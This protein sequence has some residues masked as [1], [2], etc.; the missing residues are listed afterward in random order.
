[1]K[2]IIVSMLMFAIVG[3]A[4]AQTPEEKAV[5]KAQ[6]AALKAAQKEAKAQVQQ[7]MKLRDAVMALYT[8]NQAEI[9]KGDK[10][11]KET[12]VKNE[13]QIKIQSL[14]AQEL[15]S[16]AFASGNIE[17][18]LM[19][20]AGK[21]YDDVCSQ[22]LNPELQL[23]AAHETFDTLTFSKAIDGVCDG[24]YAVL[25][26]GK[27]KDELQKPIILNSELKMPKLMTYYAYLCIFYT[28]TKNIDKAAEAMEKYAAFPTKYPKVANDPAITNP[29]YPVEQFAFN[30]YL[31]AY[32]MKKYDICEK[33]YE[34]AFAYDNPESHNFVVSSRPQIYLNQGD[35]ANWENSLKEMI[36]AEPNSNNAEVATQNL[37]VHYSRKGT[38]S[39]QK[40]ADEI[41]AI[42]PNN[43]IA[44]YGKGY[45][46]FASEKFE[47]A[48]GYY[49]KAMEADPDYYDAVYMAGM[50]Q[51]R[52]AVT[53]NFKYVDGKKYKSQAEVNAAEEKY[54]KKYFRQALPLFEKAREMQPDRSDDWASAL[55]TI[56]KNL[57]QKDKADELKQYLQ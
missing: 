42:D 36:K 4:S 31:T 43:K 28:E 10:A 55:S 20:D 35:T 44:N 7:G 11:N 9:A 1:M 5:A 25:E 47:D 51:Y 15:L 18:K 53:N 8:A 26:Y 24:C 23:A 34:Q 14:E 13:A 45:A 30:I 19:F 16:K 22:L 33:F 6:A 50:S 21:A 37:L 27:M 49:T 41:L 56:Y 54:V 48:Y 12:I 46:M 29:Q 17:E 3:A 40:F 52:L 39:L 38:D 32:N 2:K 57:G